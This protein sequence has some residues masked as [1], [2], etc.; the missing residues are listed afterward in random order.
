MHLKS[1]PRVDWSVHSFVVVADGCSICHHPP[2]LHEPTCSTLLEAAPKPGAL[3]LHTGSGAVGKVEH[4]FIPG[5]Y[6]DPGARFP[7]PFTVVALSTGD[8]LLCKP[9]EEGDFVELTDREATL[10]EALI[11]ELRAAFERTAEAVDLML[12]PTV[13]VSPIVTAALREATRRK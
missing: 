1:D 3:V 10:Y 13:R 4:V 9:G 5:A 2:P 6:C 12:I 7:I 11:R 8:K